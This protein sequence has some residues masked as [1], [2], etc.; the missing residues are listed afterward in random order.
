[1]GP[2]AVGFAVVLV[3]VVLLFV[4]RCNLCLTVL[5]AAVVVVDV[6]LLGR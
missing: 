3:L 5:G 6:L 4:W 2:A 1:M